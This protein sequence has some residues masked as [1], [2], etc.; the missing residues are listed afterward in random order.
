[1]KHGNNGVTENTVK[2]IVFGGEGLFLT[3]VKGPGT[4][5]L[6]SMPMSKLANM[7]YM[8]PKN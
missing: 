8:G 2:N 6:Q 7:L 3:T 1:M 4:I 5:W